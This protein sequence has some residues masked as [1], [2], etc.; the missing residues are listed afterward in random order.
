M[1]FAGAFS[2]IFNLWRMVLPAMFLGCLIGTWIQG[3]R[4]WQICGRLMAPLVAMARLPHNCGL[5]FVMC[6]L[7]HY[8]AN[9]YLGSEFQKGMVRP[10]ELLAAFLMG[11]FP[12]GFHFALFYIAPILIGSVGWE[13][14][15]SYT[16]LYLTIG[17]LTAGV[18]ILIGLRGEKKVLSHEE[19]AC[20][21]S[22]STKAGKRGFSSILSESGKQFGRMALI[23]VPVTLLFALGMHHEKIS[24]L[25]TSTDRLAGVIGFSGP[26]MIVVAAGL[27]SSISA[28]AAA[29]AL[30]QSRLLGPTEVVYALLIAYAMHNI[31]E[32]FANYIPS[33][34]AFFGPRVGL[35]VAVLHLLTRLSAILLVLA[36]IFLVK[37]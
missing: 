6:F 29:A 8:A 14:G 19:A 27:P 2:Q 15:A 28:L 12:N 1:N 36:T 35:R 3:T 23:F 26:V 4:L 16:A 30:F 13:V 20:G 33:T 7:N 10:R 34:M 22:P 17:L 9:A 21:N 31:Y 24:Q 11:G 5:Y 18:G 32:F 25:L 37:M